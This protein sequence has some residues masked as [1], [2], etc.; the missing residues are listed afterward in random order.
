MHALGPG[1]I[2]AVT[3]SERAVTDD[4]PSL[5]YHPLRHPAPEFHGPYDLE[6]ARTMVVIW[7]GRADSVAPLEGAQPALV[8]EIAAWRKTA[9]QKSLADLQRY[10]KLAGR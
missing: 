7:R 1:E 5:E 9:S 3:S 2:R 10:W 8:A 4:R 6:H